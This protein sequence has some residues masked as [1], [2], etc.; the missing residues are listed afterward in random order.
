MNAILDRLAQDA[1][2]PALPA[3]TNGHALVAPSGS[4]RDQLRALER[5][6]TPIRVG[7]VGAGQMGAGLVSQAERI[8]GISVVAVADIAA[9]RALAAYRHATVSPGDLE[10]T[11]SVEAASQAIRQGRRV[12]T[13]DPSLIWQIPEVDVVVEATGVP[14][15]GARTA[16]EAILARKHIVMLNVETDVT[17]GPFLKQLADAAGV[18]YS[19]SAGDEPG[20]IKELFDFADTL[21]FDVVAA[22]KGKNNPLDRSASAASLADEARQKQMN[23]KMLASFVDGTKTMVEMAAVSNG[24]G[25]RPEVAGMYGPNATVDQLATTFCPREDGGILTARGAVDFAVGVAPGVFVII[26]TDQPEVVRDLQYLKV[27]PGPYWALYRPYH[28]ANLET[29][30]SV[31]RAALRHEATL[32]PGRV[33]LA[34]VVAT[35]KRGLQPGDLIDGIG[36]ECTYGLIY[37]A[38]EARGIGAVP[39]GLAAGARVTRAIARGEPLRYDDVELD[40]SQTIFRLRQLQDQRL[41]GSA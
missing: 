3:R 6:G 19:L 40:E 13:G 5:A 10:T 20:S 16:F 27:G 11:S 34:E 26:A 9:E 33:P 36:G 41:I 14:E 30:I 21:G 8:A 39:I 38:S 18:V 25:L 23:P 22:G 28:L 29:P 12:A 17:V 4:L 24:T 15:V 2:G 32:V 37:R 35:A 7:L 31:A 1:A